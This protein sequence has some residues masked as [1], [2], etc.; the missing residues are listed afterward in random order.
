[1]G[2]WLNYG[3]GGFRGTSAV[4]PKTVTL[5]RRLSSLE[6]RVSISHELCRSPHTS[7]LGISIDRYEMSRF[8]ELIHDHPNRI[9]LAGCHG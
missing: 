9:K 7:L 1:M 3:S 2:G 4:A 6:F 5:G 8:G